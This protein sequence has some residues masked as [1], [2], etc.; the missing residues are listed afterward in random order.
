MARIPVTF[1]HKGKQF[2]GELVPVHGMAQPCVWHLLIDNRYYGTLMHTQKG[3]IIH[4]EWMPELA[5]FLGDYVTA[6]YQ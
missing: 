5:D 2:K 4:S 1:E 3:W 6:W